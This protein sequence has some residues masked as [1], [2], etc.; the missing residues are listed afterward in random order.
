MADAAESGDDDDATIEIP[1]PN[2]EDPELELNDMANFYLFKTW[3][4][5]GQAPITLTEFDNMGT[6]T[7][8]D[9]KKLLAKYS[10]LRKSFK[11]K[12]RDEEEMRTKR[13]GKGGLFRG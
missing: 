9:F 6:P 3:W 5:A 8:E 12:R 13:K 10:V 2:D 1:D 7:W 11:K 4:E